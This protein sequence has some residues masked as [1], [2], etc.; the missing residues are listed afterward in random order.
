MT[1]KVVTIMSLLRPRWELYWARWKS[2]VAPI[3][4]VP[5]LCNSSAYL[6]QGTTSLLFHTLPKIH[7][8]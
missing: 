2:N 8:I 7:P 4:K 5:I 3:F 1:V 6:P